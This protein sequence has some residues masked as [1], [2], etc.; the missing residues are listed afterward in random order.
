[1]FGVKNIKGKRRTCL[2]RWEPRNG[3]K[4]VF[5]FDTGDGRYS[6]DQVGIRIGTMGQSRGF[7]NPKQI[8]NTEHGPVYWLNDYER[9]LIS[10]HKHTREDGD[11]E[12]PYSSSRIHGVG[13]RSRIYWT[14]YAM[15]ECLQRA[16]SSILTAPRLVSSCGD[17]LPTIHWPKNKCDKLPSNTLA[18]AV[19]RSWSQCGRR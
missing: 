10:I 4:L 6:G 2:V 5:R 12:D 8:Q 9:Q 3:D 18:A 7:L 1:M 15:V 14:W 16:R 13:I 19:L 11:F 17:T